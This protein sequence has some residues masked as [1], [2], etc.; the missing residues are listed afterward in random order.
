MRI[1]LSIAVTLLSIIGCNNDPR[2]KLPQTGA[3]GKTFTESNIKTVG[4]VVNNIDSVNNTN[5]QL[6]GTISQYCTGE[7]CWLTLKNT[8]GDDIFVNVKDKAFVLPYNIEGK[9]AI[10]NGIANKDTTPQNTKLSIEA[11]GIVIRE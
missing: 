11:V 1:S 10:V 2:M 7:G 9:T 6:R 3:Y 8:D 4:E 5:I